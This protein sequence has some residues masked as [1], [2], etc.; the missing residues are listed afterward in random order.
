MTGVQT[1]AL[2][3][4]YLVFPVMARDR[5]GM[6]ILMEP[7]RFVREL[8]GEVYEKWVISSE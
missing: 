1:C 5:A 7:S 8:P 3:I 2:P 4:L 6:D